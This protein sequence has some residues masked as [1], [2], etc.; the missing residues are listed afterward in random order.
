MI[1][2]RTP[3]RALLDRIEQKLSSL[4]LSPEGI[5]VQTS[6]ASEIST[7]VL[8]LACHPS[9]FTSYLLACK[10]HSPFTIAT[11]HHQEGKT[12]V[13]HGLTHLTFPLLCFLYSFYGCSSFNHVNPAHV[14]RWLFIILEGKKSQCFSPV[15]FHLAPCS[16]LSN[17]SICFENV[18]GLHLLITFSRFFWYLT[19]S[20]SL[21]W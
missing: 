13:S 6:Y 21:L 15:I 16:L 17:D 5:C 14:C 7:Q 10:L 20:H 8:N 3:A 19:H 18:S 11:T 12:N 2:G 9:Y 1:Y 4:I